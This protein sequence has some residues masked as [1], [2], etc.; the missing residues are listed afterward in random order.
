MLAAIKNLSR[1]RPFLK[2]LREVL[3]WRLQS[4]LILR[5]WRKVTLK[6][7]TKVGPI[8]LT[9][10]EQNTKSVTLL[11]SGPQK[12]KKEKPRRSK[13]N[14]SLNE[15]QENR[16]RVNLKFRKADCSSKNSFERMQTLHFLPHQMWKR[17]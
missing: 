5:L 1:R 8:P 12:D 14:Q 13:S 4:Q 2:F 6:K 10:L 7:T 15:A 16:S 11:P 9:N 17:E 3:H